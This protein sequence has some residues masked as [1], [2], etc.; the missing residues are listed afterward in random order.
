ML[1]IG[2]APAIGFGTNILI[3]VLSARLA[4]HP[5]FPNSLGR[6]HATL[7]THTLP[8]VKDIHESAPLSPGLDHAGALFT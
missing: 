2:L 4:G 3:A 5:R 8:P 1:Y 6:H 7:P